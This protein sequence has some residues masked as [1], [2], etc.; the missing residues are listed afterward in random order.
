MKDRIY[1]LI[2]FSSEEFT[3]DLYKNGTVFLNTF[4]YFQSQENNNYRGDPDEATI[5]IK[6]FDNPE[7]YTIEFTDTKTGESFKKIPGDLQFG[8][9]NLTPGNLYCMSCIRLSDF[10]NNEFKIDSK[11]KEFGSHAL[12]INNPNIFMKRLENEIKKLK[13]EFKANA[14]SYYDKWK[15][16]GPLTLFHKS[17]EYAYQNEY[18]ILVPNKTINPIKFKLG[19][20]SDISEIV[21]T[22]DILDITFKIN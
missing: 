14:V 6:N 19:D 22:E 3:N 18:R 12:L 10:E 11:L 17:T 4:E 5:H 16:N 21:K 1:R 15:H 2:K 7:N 9:K 8:Y 20:L 13:S